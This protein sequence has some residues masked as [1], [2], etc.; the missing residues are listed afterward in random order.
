MPRATSA[1][2]AVFSSSG[3][4]PTTSTRLFVV[5]FFKASSTAVMPPVEGGGNAVPGPDESENT[6]THNASTA[7]ARRARFMEEEILD[8]KAENGKGKRDD[9]QSFVYRFP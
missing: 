7:T 4:A 5:S 1:R 9:W 3:W 8:R 2:R 6:G